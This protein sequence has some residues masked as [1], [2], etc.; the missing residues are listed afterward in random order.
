[1]TRSTLNVRLVHSARTTLAL[2][3]VALLACTEPAT[4]PPTPTSL[5][6]SADRSLVNASPAAAS[7]LAWEQR[8][9]NLVASNGFSP[10]NAVRLY[11][12]HSIAQYAAIVAA[13]H[14]GGRSNFA[15][16]GAVAG[17][18]AQL[19]SFLVPSAA[20]SLEA[21]VVADGIG[22][23]GRTPA[24]FTRGVAVG[25]TAGDAMIAWAKR[26]GFSLV[27]NE[28][29]R[30][31]PGW[32][33]W[34]GANPPPPVVRPA[35]AGFQFPKMTPYFLKA[36]GDRAAQ[37][38]FRPAAPPPYA[39]VGDGR[40]MKDLDQ[41]RQ[42]SLHRT[43]QQIDIAIFWNLAGGTPTALGYWDQQAA[44]FVAGAQFDELA[45]AHLFA[46]LNAAAMDATIGCWEAKYHFLVVRP[47]MADPSITTVYPLP[48][49]PSYPSGH[50]CVSSAAAT[51][52]SAYFPAQSDK[53]HADV[54]EA[55]L[56]RIYGGIHFQFDVA[57]GQK[58][59]SS[60]ALWA[61]AYDRR[62]GLLA[63]VGLAQEGK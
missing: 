59:G 7:T 62:Q 18:S 43:Q 51:V 56:S 54:I 27:W 22:P 20:A 50:S 40:F 41:V 4:A 25:R 55:G 53:L 44:L 29:M 36:I 21:Q 12:L 10:I 24:Q 28:S 61:M 45:A 47:T 57:A 33:I 34:Q 37:R 5:T 17:A 8:A 2:S 46:L 9:R 11:A 49:H 58:L 63:A 3:I 39:V 52:L 1:M 42:I 16:R 23:E 32:G 31:A 60:T 19:L 30:N 14:S 13:D 6:P 48:N 26:D 15:R 35:P 38:Q